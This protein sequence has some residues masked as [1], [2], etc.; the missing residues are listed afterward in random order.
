M[1]ML[2][3]ERVV[4]QEKVNEEIRCRICLGILWDPKECKVCETCFCGPCLDQ[5][6]STEG[7]KCPLKCSE[8]P[9]FKE[10][11][12]KIIRNML[13]DLNFRCK[14]SHSGCQEIVEYSKILDHERTCDF[15]LKECSGKE[16]GCTTVLTKRELTQHEANCP[17]VPVECEYCKR[18]VKRFSLRSHYMACEEAELECE[19]CHGIFKKKNYPIHVN[20]LCEENIM[21]C[22]KCSGTYKR[23]YK[24][25]HDCV[26]HLQNCQK[27][28]NEEIT[29]L[30]KRLI[31]KDKRINELES[32][33]FYEMA[34]IRAQI[35]L[36]AVSR[37]SENHPLS[38][39]REIDYVQTSDRG[40]V[41]ELGIP[42]SNVI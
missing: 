37:N 35:E 33:V 32:R 12:H 10:R 25:Y 34:D 22:G 9:E 3:C 29:G 36:L 2:S 24:Q 8:E 13:S 18:M 15:D 5:W 21:N 38:Q 16:D 14:N 28:M 23:K 41:L 40:E 1:M 17:L 19:M 30:K 11:A 31:E 6:L 27:T 20:A 42:P 26:R 4:N 39:R 7:H